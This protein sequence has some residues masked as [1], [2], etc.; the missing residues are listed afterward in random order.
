ML[1]V[2][3]VIG[4]IFY[5]NWRYEQELDS[6]L[7]KVD[8]RDIQ[9]NGE[10]NANGLGP[11]VTRVSVEDLTMNAYQVI[12]SSEFSVQEFKKVESRIRRQKRIWLIKMSKRCYES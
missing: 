8:F 3:A 12:T 10:P 1:L 7:W 6:L 5:R 11:K 2:V 9:I 4:L